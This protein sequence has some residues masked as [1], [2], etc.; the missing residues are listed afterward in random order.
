VYNALVAFLIF[1][2]GWHNNHHAFPT[3]ARQGLRWYQW[4][5]AWYSI[6]VLKTLGLATSVQLPSAAVIRR[7]AA[8]ADGQPSHSTP[9]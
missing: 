7:S 9:V 3:S 1:G 2:E 4:D 6:W 5:P 8:A